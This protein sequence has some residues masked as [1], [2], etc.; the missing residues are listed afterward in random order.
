MSCHSM[1]QS[2]GSATLKQKICYMIHFYQ[3][4][5]T[6]IFWDFIKYLMLLYEISWNMLCYF[7]W[8]SY[9]SA[10][11]DQQICFPFSYD[12]IL[13]NISNKYFPLLYKI[14]YVI[15][16]NILKNI[17]LL[18]VTELRL[19]HSRSANLFPIFLWF[20]FIKYQKQIFSI[21]L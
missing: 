7:M 19:S 17:M 11:L 15:S 13:S 18:Y 14:S 4:S 3:I 8:E 16:S 5:L 1:W 12:S 2:S 20:N 21:T 6:N 10:T 9:G